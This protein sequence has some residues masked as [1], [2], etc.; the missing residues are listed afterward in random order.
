[1]CADTIKYNIQLWIK[2]KVKNYKNKLLNE[3]NTK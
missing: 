2:Q 1:M 3:V